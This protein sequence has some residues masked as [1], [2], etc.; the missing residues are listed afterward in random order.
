MA[1]VKPTLA[2]PQLHRLDA[3]FWL[4]DILE[5]I[6]SKISY[7]I[8]MNNLLCTPNHTLIRANGTQAGR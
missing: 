4:V 6:V 3:K 7:C 8:L 5:S 2:K 1:L